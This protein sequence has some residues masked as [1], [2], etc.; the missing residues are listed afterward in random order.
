MR[1]VYFVDTTLR[2]GEQAPGVAFTVQEKVQIAKMLDS[3]GIEYIEAGIP[4]MGS[5]EEE[6]IKE[7]VELGLKAAIPTWNRVN[8]SDIKASLS[9]GVKHIHVSAPVSDIHIDSKLG[10]NRGWVI[11]SMK[12]AVCYAIERGCRVTVGAE[13]ASRADPE[14]LIRFT[15]HARREGAERLR[16][17][18]T[19]GVLEPFRTKQII[20]MII[21]S[22][23]M[24]IEFH[25]HNDF[26]L[27]TANTYAAFKAGA[28]FLSTTIGGLGER[29]GNCSFEEIL[30]VL[31]QHEGIDLN[32][33]DNLLAST[34]YYLKAASG[35]F[36]SAKQPKVRR[37]SWQ[38]L[39]GSN[40][41]LIPLGFLTGLS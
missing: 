35:R 13:D 26:G 1:H 28:V 9:C 38:E 16:F 11:E 15:V 10:K 25:G 23:G 32:V 14:F 33:N 31:K 20:D 4:A 7:I 40:P 8:I 3:L 36:E 2:N 18:D 29:A 30:A 27:A 21:E 41:I 37:R 5:P 19:V 24:D 17:A 22:T 34:S 12:R 39:Y 6:A